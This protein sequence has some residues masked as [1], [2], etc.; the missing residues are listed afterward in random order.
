MTEADWLRCTGPML[1]FVRGKA[2]ERKLRLFAWYM[3]T[4]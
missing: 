2:S 3:I 1:D 4:G